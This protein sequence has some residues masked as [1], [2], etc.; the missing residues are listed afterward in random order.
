MIGKVKEPDKTTTERRLIQVDVT[1]RQ[2][3]IGPAKMCVIRK[4][5]SR[6]GGLHGVY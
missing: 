4:V 5:K 3:V 1:V 6:G 2:K